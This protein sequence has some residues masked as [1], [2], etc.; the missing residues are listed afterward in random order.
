MRLSEME[1]TKIKE[2]IHAQFGPD[3]QV[4]L[5]GSRA[6]D[7]KKGGDIDLLVSSGSIVGVYP[8]IIKAMTAIQF[9]IGDR[10]IDLIVTDDIRNDSRLVVQ[11][12][13]TNGVPL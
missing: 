7:A 4:Y 10:K 1:R 12:A 5:F 8:R 11:E 13:A 6:D 9:A 3:S 2:A